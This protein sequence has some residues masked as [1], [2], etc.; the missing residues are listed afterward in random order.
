MQS[1]NPFVVKRVIL[2]GEGNRGERLP[3]LLDRATRA[4][5]TLQMTWALSSRRALPVSANTMERELRYLAHLEVWLRKNN[6]SLSDPLDFVERFT[7]NRIE[8]SLRPWLGKDMS[9]R[10]VKKLSVSPTEIKNRILV[11]ATF[12]DWVLGNAERSLSF[13]TESAK[14]IAFSN[15]RSSISRTLED[16]LP[17]QSNQ[18]DVEGLSS[19]DAIKLLLAIHP[20]NPKNVWARGDEFHA[21]QIRRRNYLIVLLC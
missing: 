17:T 4:P 11:I 13:R 6:L 20:D 21:K 18:S 3:M 9:G 19:A 12:I 14:C 5:L 8:N 10:K 15:A 1:Q 16:I 7:P 2:K